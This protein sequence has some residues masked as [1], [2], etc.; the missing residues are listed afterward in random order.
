MKEVTI[1]DD[2]MECIEFRDA[3]KADISKLFL[4]ITRFNILGEKSVVDMVMLN[5]KEA[6]ELL[7]F[8]RDNEASIHDMK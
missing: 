4:T 5:K 6:L 1:R 3:V 7:N 8:L 2:R